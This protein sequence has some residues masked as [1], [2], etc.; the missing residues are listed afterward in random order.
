[1]KLK[2]LSKKLY[3]NNDKTYNLLKAA[4]ELQ[5]LSLALIQQVNKI[6]SD[7]TKNIIEEI[8]DVELRLA[9]VKR[10]YSSKAIDKRIRRKSKSILKHLKTNKYK[11]KV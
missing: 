4:E 10:Y 7:N 9:V 6:N 3:K 2:K 8:G 1:M 5:E 11:D